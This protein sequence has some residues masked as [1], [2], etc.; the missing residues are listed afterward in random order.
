M[1]GIYKIT[2]PSGKIYIGQSWNISKRKSYYKNNPNKSQC[3]IYNSLCKY[4]FENHTFEVIHILPNDITQDILDIYECLYMELYKDCNIELMNIR[5]G[6]SKGKLS[7]ET[8]EKMRKTTHGRDFL[9]E[10]NKRKDRYKR[11]KGFWSNRKHPREY[12]LVQ[13]DLNMNHVK[14]WNSISEV[15][16]ELKYNRENISK[17]INNNSKYKNSYWVKSQ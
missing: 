8:I 1:I 9:T 5:N 14:N 2:S 11:P 15:C 16:K 10:Y 3:Y 13:Y 17:A 12:K 6:G 4:G 7:I